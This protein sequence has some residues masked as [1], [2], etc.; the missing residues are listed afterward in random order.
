MIK[1]YLP[2]T[3]KHK[4]TKQLVRLGKPNHGGFLVSL[5][6][7]KNS[8][9]LISLGLTEEWSFERDFVASKQM[10]VLAYGVSVGNRYLTEHFFKSLLSIHRPKLAWYWLRTLM[11]YR[12]FFRA[13]NTHIEQLIGPKFSEKYTTLQEV[14]D[15]VDS[16]NIYLKIDIEGNEYRILDELIRNQNRITGL[17]IEFHDCDIHI[18][19]IQQFIDAFSL[20]IIHIHPNNYAPVRVSSGLPLVL[21]MTFSAGQEAEEDCVYP[22]PLDMP[23]NP[24]SEEIQICFTA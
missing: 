12:K 24:T 15:S 6:D 1:A 11:N 19:R 13:T 20:S 3:F 21:N 5:N 10:P 22:H 7:I 17:V 14:F 18:E 8:D 9:L 23:N 2:K 16:K 4:T